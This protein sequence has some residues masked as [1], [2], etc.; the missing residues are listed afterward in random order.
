MTKTKKIAKAVVVLIENMRFGFAMIDFDKNALPSQAV[1]SWLARV[2]FLA[3]LALM[4]CF[5]PRSEQVFF[6]ALIASCMHFLACLMPVTCIFSRF[7]AGDISFSALIASCMHFP[8]LWGWWHIFSRAYRQLHVFSL[9]RDVACML[10]PAPWR[11][12]HFFSRLMASCMHFPAHL[13]PVACTF[14]CFLLPRKVSR[15]LRSMADPRLSIKS[16]L[17]N[18]P[19]LQYSDKNLYRRNKCKKNIKVKLRWHEQSPLPYS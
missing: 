8:A 4:T 6:P 5:I 11:W 3:R 18:P 1:T 7:G 15:S 19:L 17:E 14:S 2:R 12:Q 10:F 13:V 9:A 16:R